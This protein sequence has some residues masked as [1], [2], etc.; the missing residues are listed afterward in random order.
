[1]FCS[2]PEKKIHQVI[3]AMT[4]SNNNS[5]I[6]GNFPLVQSTKH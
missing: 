4:N 3:T 2:S 5:N 1:M 6:K